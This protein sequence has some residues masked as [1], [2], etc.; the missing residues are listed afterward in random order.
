MLRTRRTYRY[1][2]EIRV[3]GTWKHVFIRAWNEYE[4]SDLLIYAD[5]LIDSH[6][7]PLIDL[8][9]LRQELD[10]GR[11]APLPEEGSRAS[12]DAISW[13]FN[14]V[15]TRVDADMFVGEV[16]DIIDRLNGRPDSA[17]RC[18]AAVAAYL[19]DM[20]EDNRLLLRERYLAV[21]EHRRRR[22]LRGRDDALRVLTTDVGDSSSE[23]ITAEDHADAVATL[24]GKLR[25]DA[26]TA[27]T[28]A[29]V[30]TRV[31]ADGPVEATN[32]PI[33]IY[34]T[35]RPD[36]RGLSNYFPAPIVVDG[37]IYPTVAHAYWALSTD[38]VQWRDRIAAEPNP[39]QVSDLAAEA[40]RRPEWPKLRLAVMHRLLHIKYEQHT[41][42]ARSLLATGDAPMI[43]A[44]H[45][46]SDYWGEGGGNWI[47]RLLEVVRSELLAAEALRPSSPSPVE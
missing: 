37:Q 41:E 3:D 39:Y 25:R 42:L 16:G 34:S 10:A 45:G 28:N 44:E 15:R 7:G 1:V 4:L 17:G 5:G 9:G 23:T 27:A 40:P 11:I 8:S 47:G 31:Q 20:S 6:S 30:R 46:V 26:D 36:L 33:Y 13:Q 24:R 22:A 12:A 18:L 19:D 21:P 35:R 29:A 32:P 14:D 2:D 38:D 43:C